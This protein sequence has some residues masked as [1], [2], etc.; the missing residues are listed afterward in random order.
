M[1]VCE[2]EVDS[3]QGDVHSCC[4]LI[5]G[6]TVDRYIVCNKNCLSIPPGVQYLSLLSKLAEPEKRLGCGVIM[7]PVKVRSGTKQKE[8]R[9]LAPVDSY[10]STHVPASDR[11]Q[12]LSFTHTT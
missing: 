2:R 1:D 7:L 8:S 10:S 9:S 12:D 5:G 4:H 6:W 11:S 3:L